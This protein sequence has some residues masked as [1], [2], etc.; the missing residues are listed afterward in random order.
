MRQRKHREHGNFGF[1][2]LLI[3]V[4]AVLIAVSIDWSRFSESEIEE[5]MGFTVHEELAKHPSLAKKSFK[6]VIGDETIESVQ[7]YKKNDV[8]VKEVD[9]LVELE[10]SLEKDLEEFTSQKYIRMNNVIINGQY[11]L[12]SNS[13]VLSFANLNG[14]VYA[15]VKPPTQEDMAKVLVK[16]SE[17]YQEIVNPI[18]G[19]LVINPSLL[20]IDF[21][22]IVGDSNKSS[23][24]PPAHL[25]KTYDD[26]EK[27]LETNLEKFLEDNKNKTILDNDLL[28][29]NQYHFYL[30]EGKWELVNY[31]GETV[32]LSKLYKDGE[33]IDTPLK[34]ED[35]FKYRP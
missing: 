1:F 14:Y 9:E 8:D 29:N 19:Y 34:K 32:D 11:Q 7:L 18:E 28:I 26:F 5:R 23:F 16:P 21:D 2:V 6:M 13:G 33:V 35:Y 27:M 25:K 10:S 20:S 30:A 3:I 15:A 22:I 17:V 4:A 24:T 31:N 12:I